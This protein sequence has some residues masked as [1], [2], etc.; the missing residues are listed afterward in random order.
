MGRP[1]QRATHKLTT[2]EAD[3]YRAHGNHERESVHHVHE[4]T[5]PL[6]DFSQFPEQ[7]VSPELAWND[8]MYHGCCQHR[9]QPNRHFV[10]PRVDCFSPYLSPPLL[11]IGMA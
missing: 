9:A 4:L 8:G 5:V 11:P 1:R 6:T 3:S 10:E 7:L 2:L